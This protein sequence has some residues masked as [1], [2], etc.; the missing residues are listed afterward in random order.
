MS[1]S[2]VFRPRL[3]RSAFM[4]ASLTLTAFALPTTTTIASPSVQAPDDQ[5]AALKQSIQENQVR[6]KRYEW[7]ETTAVSLKGDE[8]SRKQN[9]CYYGADGKQQKV[10]IASDAP[11]EAPKR[12]LRGRIIEKKKEELT[13]Y[14]QQAVALVHAY[15]PPDPE[16]IQAAKNAGKIAV[17]PLPGNRMSIEINDYRMQGDL[18]T[19]EFDRSLSRILHVRIASYIE[20]PQDA[21][22]LDVQFSALPDGTN[23]PGVVTLDAPAKNIRVAVENTGYRMGR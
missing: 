22:T 9:Q 1:T 19:F 16:L 18:V 21:I 23:H 13:D 20:S 10:P 6:L 3:S 12:G 4:V 5:V 8:K 2:V 7:I 11:Q 15:V 14:M 17:R